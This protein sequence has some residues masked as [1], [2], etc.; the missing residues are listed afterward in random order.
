MDG[1]PTEVKIRLTLSKNS[2][3]AGGGKRGRRGTS[4]CGGGSGGG[5]GGGMNVSY[6]IC[7]NG[8]NLFKSQFF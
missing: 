7:W 6:I 2:G 4:V 1:N 5:G 3:G 8:E